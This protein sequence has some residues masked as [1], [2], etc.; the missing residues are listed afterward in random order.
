MPPQVPHAQ[1]NCFPG[2]FCKISATKRAVG[3]G[4]LRPG[5]LLGETRCALG[6]C[7]AWAAGG[8]GSLPGWVGGG[9]GGAAAILLPKGSLASFSSCASLQ[10]DGAPMGPISWADPQVLWRCSHS[11]VLA[12]PLSLPISSA[13]PTP[14]CYCLLVWPTQMCG[15]CRRPQSSCL[16]AE[17]RARWLLP[18]PL[19]P[20]LRP[21]QWH[22]CVRG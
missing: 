12:L 11:P 21:G 10:A 1:L 5:L 18:V 9:D 8:R 15:Q 2:C 20:G 17:C 7:I 6:R 16:G 13:S 14:P 3:F 22:R 4:Q 19:S